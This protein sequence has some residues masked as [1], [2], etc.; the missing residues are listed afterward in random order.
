MLFRSSQSARN[1]VD[2]KTILV[3][4][5]NGRK[6][7][8]LRKTLEPEVRGVV[9]VCE[10]GGN[11]ITVMQITEAVKTALGIP[12]TRVCVAPLSDSD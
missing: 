9:V 8:L 2:Q 1:T 7:A 5:A 11:P 12:S 6:T 10:G 4:D 3:E